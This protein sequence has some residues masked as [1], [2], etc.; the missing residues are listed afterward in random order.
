MNEQNIQIDSYL[1]ELAQL[2]ARVSEL[3]AAEAGRK[4]TEEQFRAFVETTNEWIWAID[5]EAR[6]TYC[7]PALKTILGY[8]PEEL[9]VGSCLVYMHEEDQLKVSEMLKEKIARKEGWS[10][11]MLRWR[12]K[13]GGYRYLESTA[14]PILDEQGNV[15]GFQGSDRDISERKHAEEALRESEARFRSLVETTSDWI[16]EVDAN[17]IYTYCSPKVIDLLGYE[18][19]E[20]IGKSPYDLMPPGEACRLAPQVAQLMA[21]AKPLIRIENINLHKDGRQV[22]LETSGVPILDNQGGLKGYRGIDRDITRR[23]QAE[24]ALRISE[25]QYRML[26]ETMAQGVV[27]QNADG[28][29]TSANPAA[30]RILGLSLDQMVGRTSLDPRWRA[31]R[32]DGS[33]FPGDQHPSM[34]AL[35]T[36]QPIN[37]VIMGVFHPV[38]QRHRWIT[39]DA[40][41]QFPPGGTTP[42]TVY[43]TFTDITERKETERVLQEEFAF[44]NAIIECAAEGLCVWHEVPDFP[45]LVFTVWNNCMTEITGCSIDEINR[46]GW[47]QSLYPDP[48]VQARARERVARIQSGDDMKGEEREI[49]R[50]D[51]TKRLVAIST[52]ILRKKAG[53]IHIL[54]LIQDLTERKRA[55][56]E[57]LKLEAQMQRAQKLESLGILAGGIAHDFNN[58][59]TAILGHAN[60]AMLELPAESGVRPSIKAIEDASHRAAD[61]CRQMLAYAG[62]GRFMVEPVNLSFI[63]QELTHLLQVSVSKKAMLRCNLGSDLPAIDADP[64]QVRQ[65]IMNLVINASEAIGDKEGIVA[66]TTGVMQCDEAYLR[67]SHTAEI[68][69]PGTYV[70]VE[71][72]DTGCGMDANT[73]ARIF[74]PFFTS[75]FPGRGLGLA[76]VLGI[77]RS[78]KGAIKLESEPGKGTSFRVLFPA[79]KAAAA[80]EP[81][82]MPRLF[83]GSGLILLVDDEEPVREVAKT[84]LERCGYQVV[85]ATNGREA[86]SIFRERSAEIACVLLDLTMPQMDGEETY[87]ELRRI[88][89][90]ARVILS[91]GYGGQETS[92]RFHGLGLAGFIAKPFEA[93]VLSAMLREILNPANVKPES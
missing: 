23:K 46:L 66:V 38:E 35:R 26:F 45:Y 34:V 39:V 36:G 68:L 80:E 54:A 32:K 1:N 74:D 9:M 14:V 55:E 2:R 20:I 75:K 47:Y 51:G 62:M 7:N 64:T 12:H 56:E 21:A 84:I 6:H 31:V 52:S 61:L 24:E 42:S 60:L 41:P 19:N 58:L 83:T 18:P 15:I 88:R 30:E 85:T 82:K 8:S 33:E 70:F 13:D 53:D 40:V 27:Y 22:L 49:T 72:D 65:V 4:K 86:I 69:P 57:R 87:Y 73:R 91:S 79:S 37:N 17:V 78:H 67:E 92:R 44:R 3:E 48:V 10:G 63:V 25:E 43:T 5:L 11:L 77:V 76:A 50:S 28:R 16:W 90:N 89:E 93:S 71:V 29:I 81:A 59:L